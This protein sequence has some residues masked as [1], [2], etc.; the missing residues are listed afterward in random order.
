VT[1]HG[2]SSQASDDTIRR[3]FA[4][5]PLNEAT[6]ADSDDFRRDRDADDLLVNVFAA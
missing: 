4:N 1:G 2:P 5:L 3:L 6:L